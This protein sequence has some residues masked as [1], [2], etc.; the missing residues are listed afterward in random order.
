[1][2]NISTKTPIKIRYQ[3]NQESGFFVKI[4]INQLM[5][6]RATI[7]ETIVPVAISD[8]SEVDRFGRECS[9]TTLAP[10]IVGMP[11][12]KEKVTICARE[13]LSSVPPI[14]VAPLRDTPGTKAKI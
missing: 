3:P 10:S 12:K 6:K 14:S 4:F 8:H 13:I 1:M 5:V 2:I 7:K 11:S 9:S